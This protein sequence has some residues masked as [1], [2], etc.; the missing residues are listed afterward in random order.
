MT[1]LIFFKGFQFTQKY[2]SAFLS[3]VFS[4]FPDQWISTICDYLLSTPELAFIGSHLGIGD[5]VLYSD[6]KDYSTND[7]SKLKIVSNPP[8]VDIIANTFMALIGTLVELKVS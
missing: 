7:L 3:M 2:I 5:I 1:I 4:R 8:S 6:F